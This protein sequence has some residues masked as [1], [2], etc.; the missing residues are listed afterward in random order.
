MTLF[1]ATAFILDDPD[2]RISYSPGWQHISPSHGEYQS[3]RSSADIAGLNASF[4]FIGT[5]VEVYGSVASYD[6]FG[7]PVSTYTV[8][9]FGPN[10]T[11]RAPIVQPGSVRYNVLFYRSP[12]LP[13]GQRHTLRIINMNG[14]SPSSYVLDYIV[15]TS[16]DSGTPNSSLISA[17]PSTQLSPTSSSTSIS[18]DPTQ[19]ASGGE[20]PR[21]HTSVAAIAGGVV[22]GSL[23]LAMTI[24]AVV[25]YRRRAPRKVLQVDKVSLSS[26]D[27]EEI[28][29]FESTPYVSAGVTSSHAHSGRNVSH[30]T[31]YRPYT[32][33][34]AVDAM[35][36]PGIE[37]P[38]SP[39]QA[40]HA[41]GAPSSNDHEHAEPRVRLHSDSGVRLPP[42]VSPSVLDIPPAYTAD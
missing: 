18:T 29:P 35:E 28:T 26:S 11:F 39:I 42:T 20:V 19:T 30:N 32:S 14:T 1:N 13:A 41:G 25:F 40:V 22:G 34:A 10:T 3:T 36:A 4:S 21:Q 23:L 27:D 15:Y 6:W 2:I 8:D 12:P 33:D 5:G 16:T 31:P 9:N 24:V 7:V 37:A 17:P 38:R